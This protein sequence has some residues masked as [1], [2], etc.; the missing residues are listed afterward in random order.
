MQSSESALENTACSFDSYMNVIQPL[1]WA[2][3]TLTL[4]MLT[5]SAQM[6]TLQTKPILIT[7]SV[8]NIYLEV[9]IHIV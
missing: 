3:V 8:Q 5:S 1:G 4:P 6:W 7:L 2:R 9:S